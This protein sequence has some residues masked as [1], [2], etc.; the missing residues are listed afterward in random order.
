MFLNTIYNLLPVIGIMSI[1]F[2]FATILSK[3]WHFFSSTLK[4]E[5]AGRYESL[6]GLRGVLALGVFFQHAVT[7]LSYY[8]TGIWQITDEKFYRFLGG[9]SVILFFMITS[10]L[11]WSKAIANKGQLNAYSI[12]KNR[13]YRL[14]PMYL[15]TAAVVVLFALVETNFV[16]PDVIQFGRDIIS[17]LSLGIIT[18][19][20]VNGLSIIPINAGIH[21][22]LHFEW[23]LYI[24]LPFIAVTLRNKAM[25]FLAIP[26][27]AIIALSSDK[28]YWMIFLF[29]ILAA[30]TLSIIPK[31]TWMMKSS[32][33]LIP[34]IGLVLVYMVDYKPYGVLQYCI[35]FFVFLSFLYGNTLWGLLKTPAAK[36]LGTMSYSIYL[37]HGIVL[38]IVLKGTNMLY[39]IELL[40]PFAFWSLML[41]SALCI[42]LISGLTYRYIEYPFLKK[43]R[44]QLRDNVM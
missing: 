27:L 2:L 43:Y 15:F 9:E 36:L 44:A 28:G 16:I 18:T 4:Q 3:H 10:F 20:S 21:W 13:I 26:I 40:S 31:Q 32:A 12:Y 24:A 25:H 35:T 14:A 33:S 11:Y 5:P 19:T 1:I 22:T 41:F 29:G 7:N 17:W 30:H 38:Y 42:I 34:F 8:Q 6:D 37:I 23:I 39:P